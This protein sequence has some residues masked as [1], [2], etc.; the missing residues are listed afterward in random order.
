MKQAKTISIGA[1]YF[2][3]L[4]EKDC[5]YIDKTDFIR[6]WWDAEDVV[7]LITRPR[8]FGKTLNMSMLDC[9]FS[10][11]YQGRGELFEGLSIW[12]DE[13]FRKLQGTMPCI[14]LTFAGVKLN[15]LRGARDGIIDAIDQAYRAHAYLK[16]SDV[17]SVEEKNRFDA[18][19]RYL[20][21]DDPERKI[22]DAM[23]TTSIQQLSAW[24]HAYYQKP[25][26]ILMD[27]Y[28]TPLQE[29]WTG[30]CWQEIVDFIRA[31]FNNTFKTNRHLARAL[32][33]V[34]TRVSRDSIFS[35]LNN[36]KV[37][38]TTSPEYADAFGFTEE[39]RI[40]AL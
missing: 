1:Q 23:V 11:R 35:D 14:F 21:N 12:Q 9:F 15:T 33:T 4:R 3:R 36:M 27:E 13:R 10:M 17:L 30:G 39:E 18:L 29:A 22:D 5:F 25:V 2:D 37:V 24:L 7:T 20:A 6:Q 26:L 31:L 16:D 8:R 34:I 28:D 32:L 19:S 38:T 40:R